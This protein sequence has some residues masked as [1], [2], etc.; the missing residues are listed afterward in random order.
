ML[1]DL[2]MEFHQKLTVSRIKDSNA[3]ETDLKKLYKLIING[4]SH[5]YNIYRENVSKLLGS[6]EENK[7]DSLPYEKDL[8][9]ELFEEIIKF[10]HII[11]IETSFLEDEL[12]DSLR[13]R[14]YSILHD[15]FKKKK[16]TQIRL[17]EIELDLSALT[18]KECSDI[19]SQIINELINDSK[20]IN[21]SKDT[22]ESFIYSI[23]PLRQLLLSADNI[24]MFYHSVGILFDRLSSSEYYQLGRDFAEEVLVCSFKDE[25]TEFGFFNSFRSYSAS[26][27]VHSAFLYA[28][29][30]L[31]IA[32]GKGEPI[33]EKYL[34][35][36]IWQGMKFF[37]NIT[38]YP[39][40]V[41]IYNSIPQGLVYSTIDR[42][43]LDHT[44]FT[45][46]LLQQDPQLSEQL[47]DY[48]NKE[49]EE[50]FAGGT[51]EVI[52][53]LITLYNIKRVFD[54]ADFSQ[55]G[56]GYY[57][58]VFESIV[59]ADFIKKQ[60]DIIEGNKADLKDYLR[61]SLIKLNETRNVEDYIY[62]NENALVISNRL[63]EYSNKNK[64]AGG[65]LLAMLLKSDYSLLVQ[66]KPH[67][68]IAPLILPTIN[69]DS[70]HE[71]FEN[72]EE[73]YNSLNVSENII[74]IWLALVEKKLY[75]LS[76]LNNSFIFN[77]SLTWSYDL[78]IK[79]I[80]SN[81]FVDLKF[82]ETIKE[83]GQIREVYPEEYKTDT[84][85]IIQ[86]L[87]FAKIIMS[88]N[89]KSLYIVK[90]MPFA[91]YP[92]NLLINSE[93]EFISH[94]LP[95]T[96]ILSTEWFIKHH[97]V[98]PLEKKYSKSIWIPIDTGDW[99]LSYLYG[100]IE[101]SLK[102]NDFE[103][104]TS[105]TIE[106][107]LSSD[108]NIFCSHGKSNVSDVQIVSHLTKLTYDFDAFIGKGRILIF[109]VCHS[110]SMKMEFF[111][112]NVTSMVKRFI[113][114]G[115]EAIIAPFWA[116]DVSVPKYWFPEFLNSIESKKSIDEAVFM[117]NLK[118][119]EKIPTPAAWA[120]F[121][122][123]GNP[124]LRIK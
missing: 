50:I 74:I 115:Y 4:L 62:D 120:C 103:I 29:I 24:E 3:Y 89:A 19:A 90:D 8:F 45:I 124:N 64:D 40:A 99:A 17:S 84:K 9:F 93:G 2:L 92:H 12:E 77:E 72:Y 106:S 94:L 108:L 71:L 114:M 112:N 81:Y 88:Q 78:F 70:F 76:F 10:T 73:L 25:M 5:D 14:Y 117:A 18:R 51:N 52:P 58:N 53:W 38:M 85:T 80:N 116:L 7:E 41:Q 96:N 36:I 33:S 69:I 35:E 28:N 86:S 59:P 65:F 6:L 97:D 46:L 27:N 44:Y 104:H 13:Q 110:G 39:F 54:N 31:V 21:W 55:K 42:R 95:V 20:Q 107:P 11:K 121:H 34:K 22:V 15:Y 82:E 56:L 123:Y 83:H 57:L 119:Y 101:N 105:S 23:S 91:E 47:L 1:E 26:N 66:R 43:S 79:L 87:D 111:R 60:K 98:R 109:F 100:N 122:L 118:V 67:G 63:I 113:A 102:E 16:N 68:E 49:R 32:L 30:S 37:R 61:E 75:Q 48:L